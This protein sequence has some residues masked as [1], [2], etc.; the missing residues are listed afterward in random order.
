M[1]ATA[2]TQSPGNSD[3]LPLVSYLFLTRNRHDDLA[4][5]LR[6]ILSQD[7]PKLEIVVVDNGS[8]DD[9]AD[10]FRGEFGGDGIKYLRSETNLGVSG[11]RNLGLQ[12]V[13]G[14]IV[15]TIDDDAVLRD[16][17]ATRLAVD[18]LLSDQ[19]VGV[20]AFKIVDYW[21]G[22]LE[23]GAF[24]FNDKSLDPDLEREGTRFIGAGHAIP[25]RIYLEVGLYGEYFPW[26][27][28]EIDLSLRI[29]D[30]G[31]RIVYFPQVTVYHKKVTTRHT[32][33]N[34][35]F[36]AMQLENRIKCAIR[37]LPW[38][39]AISHIAV[40]SAEVPV[41]YTHGNPLPVFIAHWRVARRFAALLRERKPVSRQT[42]RRIVSLRGPALY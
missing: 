39:Y 15:I 3:K 33:A 19:S 21:G 12:Q 6:S 40:R 30:K 5:A 38:P 27:H 31:Y 26:G 34:T 7:Y 2:V 8:T 42:V 37:N 11:G 29:M 36:Q 14:D 28:E 17:N 13:S 20:L 9:T 25:R 22:K 18:K 41:R 4:E 24:P 10:M 23:R 32:Q 16:P 1:P 35:A